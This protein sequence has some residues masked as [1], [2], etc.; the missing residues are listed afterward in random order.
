MQKVF[1]S[2]LCLALA[3]T[4]L[5]ACGSSGGDGGGI[6]PATVVQ[7][8]YTVTTVSSTGS[9]YCS[10]D[11]GAIDVFGASVSI[12]GSTFTVTIDGT[13]YPGTISGNTVIVSTPIGPYPDE[14]GQTT[15][16]SF[17]LRATS[18]TRLEGTSNWTWT[19]GIGSCSGSDAWTANKN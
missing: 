14:G 10:S 1:A 8:T 9:S 17:T 15:I 12:S 4:G 11:N 18:T 16:T 7:G 13:P 5:A 19:D 6:D 2:V 3:L